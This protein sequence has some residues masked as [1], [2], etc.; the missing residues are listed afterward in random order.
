MAK[1]KPDEK[2]TSHMGRSCKSIQLRQRLIYKGEA[3]YW[4]LWEGTRDPGEV[5][6]VLKKLIMKYR[7]HNEIPPLLTGRS[8]MEQHCMRMPGTD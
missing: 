7:S 3:I 6:L 1:L 5:V 4:A 2:R 8:R